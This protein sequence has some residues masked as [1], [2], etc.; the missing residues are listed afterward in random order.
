ML[1]VVLLEQDSNMFDR[2]A[3]FLKER[4]LQVFKISSEEK[5]LELL[6]SQDI[7]AVVATEGNLAFIKKM[8][9]AFPMVNFA[10]A[11]GQTKEDFHHKTEGYGIFMQ[12][13]QFPEEDDASTMVLNLKRIK[14]LSTGVGE[15]KND[16]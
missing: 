16:N 1:S 9:S 6:R 11:S 3:D 14:E 4:K 7:D 15:V 13:P 12:L 10:L 5:V 8:I 2:F